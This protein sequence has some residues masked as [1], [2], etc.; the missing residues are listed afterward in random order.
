MKGGEGHGQGGGTISADATAKSNLA[1]LPW[2]LETE[3]Q[4]SQVSNYPLEVNMKVM[5]FIVGSW[6]MVK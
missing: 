2:D 3:Q 4:V 1:D 6:N 5:G